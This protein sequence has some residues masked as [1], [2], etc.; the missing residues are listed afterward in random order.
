MRPVAYTGQTGNAHNKP[1]EEHSWGSNKKDEAHD[2]PRLSKSL[3]LGLPVLRTR[4]TAVSLHTP[5]RPIRQTAVSHPPQQRQTARQHMYRE[6][7]TRANA[8][9]DTLV[10]RLFANEVGVRSVGVR[11]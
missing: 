2:V 5:G 1:P 9:P 4:Q 8:T 10:K 11:G 3:R 7:K 6:P